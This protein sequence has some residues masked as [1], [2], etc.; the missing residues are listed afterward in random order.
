M[1]NCQH[2]MALHRLWE[3]GKD[4]TRVFSHSSGKMIELMITE[5]VWRNRSAGKLVVNT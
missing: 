5:H 3:N 1:S 2:C 4:L